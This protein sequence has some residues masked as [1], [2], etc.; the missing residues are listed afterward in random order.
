VQYYCTL[1]PNSCWSHTTSSPCPSS[2]SLDF[3]TIRR[4]SST[5]VVLVPIVSVTYLTAKNEMLIGIRNYVRRVIL[6]HCMLYG[7]LKMQMYLGTSDHERHETFPCRFSGCNLA[8]IHDQYSLAPYSSFF[9]R[10]NSLRTLQLSL[11]SL[12]P[13][14]WL[15]P[16]VAPF[17]SPA[18]QTCFFPL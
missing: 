12:W 1:H 15:L 6:E 17:R 10:Q 18:S 7:C 4:F 14:I 3:G 11:S 13:D 5:T 9:D 2:S 8:L 16:V